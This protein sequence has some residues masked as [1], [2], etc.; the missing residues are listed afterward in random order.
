[1]ITLV[2]PGRRLRDRYS[3]M[4]LLPAPRRLDDALLGLTRRWPDRVLADPPDGS[5]LK[6]VMGDSGMPFLGHTV[7]YI[8]FGSNFT[9]AR[10]Q[11]FGPVWWMGAFGTR[12]VMVAGADRPA[13]CMRA[14]P[15][16]SPSATAPSSSSRTA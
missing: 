12:I 6:P 10:Y 15:R 4:F 16:R 8:R 2:S 14:G 5:G 7:D 13:P 3:S 11:R 9:R 1:M